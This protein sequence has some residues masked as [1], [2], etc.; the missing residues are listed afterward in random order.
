MPPNWLKV[1]VATACYE[2]QPRIRSRTRF[3][4]DRLF[5]DEIANECR[6]RSENL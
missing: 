2:I 3:Q 6:L 5:L 1:I 4:K